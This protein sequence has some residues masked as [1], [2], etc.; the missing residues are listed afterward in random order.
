[1]TVRQYPLSLGGKAIGHAARHYTL[2]G[3]L[4]KVSYANRTVPEVY[5]P[6]GPELGGAS[7]SE[8]QIVEMKISNYDV[9]RACV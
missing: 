4:H 3:K 7:A 6:D 9:K 1:M 2:A 5:R 8:K